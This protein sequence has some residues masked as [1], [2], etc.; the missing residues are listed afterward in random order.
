MKRLVIHPDDRSTDF[1]RPIYDGLGEITLVTGGVQKK[2]LARLIE[3]HDQVLMLGHGSPYGLMSVGQFP[4]CGGYV[5]DDKMAPLLAEKDNSVFIWC[6]ADQYVDYNLLRGFYT[7]MFISEEFEAIT[8]GVSVANEGEVEESNRSFVDVAG[9]FI[10]KGKELLL[11]AAKHEYGK[12]ALVNP[13]AT[14]N[15]DRLY[16]SE[17]GNDVWIQQ[18]KREATRQSN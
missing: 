18:E 8:M 2:D 3:S 13:V 10:D 1:L 15:N 4:F 11:A 16:V 9:R 17:G 7:G 14:Y 12:L 6:N 5:I